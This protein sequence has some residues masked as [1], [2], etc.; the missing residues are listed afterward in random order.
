MVLTKSNHQVYELS[1]TEAAQWWN[2]RLIIPRSGIRVPS[3]PLKK[4]AKMGSKFS[5]SGLFLYCQCCNKLIGPTNDLYRSLFHY[6]HRTTDPY[7]G[8]GPFSNTQHYY[9]AWCNIL[10]LTFCTN[11][12]H[13]IK[14]FA[15]VIISAQVSSLLSMSETKCCKAG[16]RL[17]H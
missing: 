3:P 14:C 12:S 17:A 11:I 7:S 8:L 1:L 13:R 15:S 2:T 6:E 5:V 4:A 16:I 9:I 10:N